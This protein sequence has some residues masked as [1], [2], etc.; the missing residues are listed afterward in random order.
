M[1]Y[2]RRAAVRRTAPTLSVT[3]YALMR[4]ASAGLPPS[5][6]PDTRRE[7]RWSVARRRPQDQ[8][9][10]NTW[11]GW[12]GWGGVCGGNATGYEP[13]AGAG[14]VLRIGRRESATPACRDEVLKA[15]VRL[16]DQTD[17]G[18][19]TAGRIFAEM[20]RRGTSYRRST[21]SKTMQ[22]MKEPD[23]GGR[24]YLQR[25]GLQG[26]RLRSRADVHRESSRHRPEMHEVDC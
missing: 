21:V 7:Q 3:S 15:M 12:F 23:V 2:S 4:V 10:H 26:F 1:K 16:E 19:F 6:N 8:Q 25:V 13:R 18:V 17:D 24:V 5:D 20:V 11:R 9:I 14:P 22:R